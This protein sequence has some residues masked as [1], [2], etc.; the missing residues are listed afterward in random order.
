MDYGNTWRTLLRAVVAGALV[1]LFGLAFCV[2]AVT[3]TGRWGRGHPLGLLF[4]FLVPPGC[5][6]LIVLPALAFRVRV[7][8]D[9]VRHVF[10][11]RFVLSERHVA[12]FVS[13]GHGAML[14]FRT[15][16]MRLVIGMHLHELAR[17]ESDLYRLQ[18][19]HFRDKA[20]PR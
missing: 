5:L 2:V 9:R 10:R 11:G 18:Q 12:D 14:V 4:V 3:V 1:G 20:R 8:G 13:V 15:G 19:Q 7:E 6:A 16:K 17:L